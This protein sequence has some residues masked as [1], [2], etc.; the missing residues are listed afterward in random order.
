MGVHTWMRAWGACATAGGCMWRHMEE[1]PYDAHTCAQCAI[2][3]LHANRAMSFYMCMRI[4]LQLMHGAGPSSRAFKCSAT[5]TAAEVRINF[6]SV[7]P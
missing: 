3:W 4:P 2:I 1:V 5:T 6:G 7:N